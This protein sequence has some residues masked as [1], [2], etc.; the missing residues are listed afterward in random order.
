MGDG[1]DRPRFDHI[2]V[3]GAHGGVVGGKE[4]DHAGD[5]DRVNQVGEAL[6]VAM[7]FEGFGRCPE[8]FLAIGHDP[9]R[10]DGV[11]ADAVVAEVARHGAG[12]AVDGCFGRSVSGETAAGL[13][14]R[15]R[16]H[17]DDGATALF[18]H[19]GGNRLD[20]E[21]HVTEVGSLAFV[22]VFRCHVFPVVAVIASR[23]V[24]E[25]VGAAEFIEE[26]GEGGLHRRDVAEIADFILDVVVGVGE[27]GAA[28]GIEV[29]EA[30]AGALGGEALDD[31]GTDALCAAGDDDG[32]VFEAGID[33]EIGHGA[34]TLKLSGF[35]GGLSPV[36]SVGQSLD[37]CVFARAGFGGRISR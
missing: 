22:P 2:V 6:A 17:V 9:A 23:V 4:D 27:F 35:F 18:D 25:D 33:C 29:E 30:D 13:P 19:R 16:T 34:R 37:G 8:F 26:A 7:C 3:G 20:G 36:V 12:E 24:D 10:H 32:F 21:E 11:D 14:P 15:I 5:V 1:L 31:F 28:F